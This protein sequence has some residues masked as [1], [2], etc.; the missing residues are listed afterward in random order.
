MARPGLPSGMK[1]KLVKIKKTLPPIIRWERELR[2][3]L[4]K[5]GK[6]LKARIQL[7]DLQ[8]L[9]D[10]FTRQ[11]SITVIE[12][13]PNWLKSA[14]VERGSKG[15]R[16]I[17]MRARELLSSSDGE[18]SQAIKNLF[19]D[20]RLNPNHLITSIPRESVTIRY[21]S[22]PSTKETELREMVGFQASRQVPFN[23]EDLVFDYKVI[24]SPHEGYSWVMLVVAQRE[25]VER[26][27]KLLQD[28]GLEPERIGLSS[29]ALFD[30]YLAYKASQDQA[31]EGCI[32][33]IDVDLSSTSLELIDEGKLLYTR[34]IPLG[35]HHLL[36]GRRSE[37][38][39]ELLKEIGLSLRAYQKEKRGERPEKLVLSKSPPLPQLKRELK[40][41]IGLPVEVIDPFKGIEGVTPIDWSQE[42]SPLSV[43][44]LAVG[45]PGISMD[46]LPQEVKEKR[47]AQSRKRELIRMGLTL[48]LIAMVSFGLFYHSSLRENSYLDHLTSQVELTQPLARRV[49]LMK[50][51]VDLFQDQMDRR[52]S[53]L[54]VLRELYRIIPHSISLRTFIYEK[55]RSVTLKGTA[56]ALSDCFELIPKLEASSLFKGVTVKYASKRKMGR[57]ELTDFQISFYVTKEGG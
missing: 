52:G 20:L 55:N 12:I 49:E 16:I 23:P 1:I 54:D 6:V 30:F 28:A 8:K 29:E 10:L 51:R 34:S 4:S 2:E 19:E 45:H 26:C 17:Q 9:R 27:L 39:H 3:I 41:E 25:K 44:G 36:Q 57:G 35:I 37:P 33:L 38:L 43:L 46:L 24:G 21:L 47:K 18:I 13:G 50:E 53:V 22:L 40:K 32:A 48:S 15:P 56:I 5:A 7:P 11:D 14:Q 31:T 42:I